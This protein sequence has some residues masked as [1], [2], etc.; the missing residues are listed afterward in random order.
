MAKA[1]KKVKQIGQE[2]DRVYQAF[3]SNRPTRKSVWNEKPTPFFGRFLEFLKHEGV[4]TVFDAGCGDGRN[5]GPFL[6]AGFAVIGMD[7]SRA[8]LEACKKHYGGDPKLRLVHGDLAGAKLGTSVDAVMCDH[9]LTHVKNIS[10]AMNS[11][12]RVLKPG[13]FALLEF[14]SPRD[15]TYGTGKR[16]SKNEFLQE[17]VYLRYD[18]L[19]DVYRHMKRFKILCITS[20]SKTDPPHGPGYIRKKRHRHHSYFV[21]AKK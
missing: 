6:D 10:A 19:E 2:W 8:A 17:G 13:G 3:H 12:Y 4:R 9:V 18:A 21:L 1:M 7:A 16:I 20:E 5:L 15:T 14:T 11:F